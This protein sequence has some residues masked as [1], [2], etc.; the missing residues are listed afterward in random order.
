MSMKNFN[1]T[2][3][4]R[5]RDLL[6]YSQCL[7]H[8]AIACP[9]PSTLNMCPFKWQG[10]LATLSLFLA[11]FCSYWATVQ[12]F[13]Q[14]VLF[15][16]KAPNLPLST[17]MECYCYACFLIVQSQI[18]LLPAFADV[19]SAGPGSV[20]EWMWSTF[21][22]LSHRLFNFHILPCVLG[23]IPTASCYILPVTIIWNLAGCRQ[24]LY[25][26][27]KEYGCSYLCSPFPFSP[28]F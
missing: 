24:V 16:K 22:W 27:R 10:L 13:A 20:S 11:G 9:P 2:I 14:R 1:D 25:D 8:C 18:T 7:N 28:L 23:P 12:L 5:S 21:V 26:C 3:G 4:N 17:Y 19:S 6:V 15:F